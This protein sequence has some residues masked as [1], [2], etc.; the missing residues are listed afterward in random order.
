LSEIENKQQ[1]K[2]DVEISDHITEKVGL[3]VRLQ[4]KKF[5]LFV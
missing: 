2:T 3:L 1:S 5:A 4:V